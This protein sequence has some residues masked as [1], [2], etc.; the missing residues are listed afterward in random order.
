MQIDWKNAYPRVQ[1]PVEFVILEVQLQRSP[2]SFA[3][4]LFGFRANQEIQLVA[5]RG[6]ESRGKITA[7][8]AGRA[9]Y[10]DLHKESDGVAALESAAPRA[11][12]PDQSSA[13]RSRDSSGRPSIS[14][15]HHRPSSGSCT[16]I[17]Y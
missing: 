2:E 11:G 13:R 12:S 1:V 6:E 17:H 10:E 4:F 14:R 8:V 15:E 3:R 5:V 9:G 7:Q 16:L